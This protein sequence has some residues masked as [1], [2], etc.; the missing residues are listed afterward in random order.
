ML[1][2]LLMRFKWYRNKRFTTLTNKIIKGDNNDLVYHIGEWLDLYK[3][4][5]INHSGVRFSPQY[6]RVG[7]AMKDV[8]FLI[9]DLECEYPDLPDRRPKQAILFEDWFIDEDYYPVSVD[10]FHQLVEDVFTEYRDQYLALE[11]DMKNHI[12]YRYADLFVTL[13]RYVEAISRRV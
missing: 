7:D 11:Y 12:D 2:N 8:L 9:E 5:L 6:D 3:D 13:R 4:R 10:P 1:R